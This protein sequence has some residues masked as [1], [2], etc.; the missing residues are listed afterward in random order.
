MNRKLRA[1]VFTAALTLT[2]FG[3]AGC[4]SPQPQTVVGMWGVPET[5]GETSLEFTEEGSYSGSDGCNV[6][7]GQ[8][9]L[10][11]DGKTVDLG[12]MHSTLMY[13]EDV[14]VWLV[15]PATAEIDGDKMVIRN[16]AGDELGTLERG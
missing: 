14:D 6:V 15:D 1:S 2:A 3:L 16:S 11:S 13:C 10:E 5:P 9:E 7:G 4:S 12:V 8:W